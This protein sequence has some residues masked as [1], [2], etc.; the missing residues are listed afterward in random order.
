MRRSEM[1]VCLSIAGSDSGGGA[2]IQADLR[3]FQFFGT[4]G[5]CAITAVTEQN[6]HEV[7]GIHPVPVDTIRGQIRA[8][9]SKLNVAAVKTGMLFSAEI[10]RA[11]AE[12]LSLLDDEVPIVVDPVM[13]ATSGAVLLQEEA[14]DSLCELL[15]PLATVITPNLPEAEILAGELMDD[16]SEAASVKLAAKLATE[17]HADVLLKGGHRQLNKA[18]DILATDK[19]VYQI[20]AP[21]VQAETTHGTGCML[22]SAIAA[23]LALGKAPHDAIVSAKAY[24]YHNLS[25]CRRIGVKAFCMQPPRSNDET[26]VA[27]S[28]LG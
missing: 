14:I 3:T 25:D 17:L 4:H 9:C 13:V 19:A 1:P 18:M 12:E 11:V 20:M 21:E 10:I 7:T 2:G 27:V 16:H 22:S 28:K 26:V 6:P 8:V 15:I 5:T 23:N 24:V